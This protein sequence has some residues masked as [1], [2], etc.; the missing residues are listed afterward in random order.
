MINLD[1]TNKSIQSLL[2][3]NDVDVVVHGCNCFHIFTGTIADTLNAATNGDI[4][5]VNKKFSSYGDI[6]NLGTSSQA[7]YFIKGK[8]VTVFNFYCQ[9]TLA[10]Q[11]CEPIHWESVYN[12][13]LELLSTVES[14]HT[15]AIANFGTNTSGQSDFISIINTL[16]QRNDDELPDIDIIVVDH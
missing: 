11:D 14:D 6:N 8:E 12:G 3:N 1:I 9:Y 4:E 2:D 10:A 15:V 16:I 13:L 5:F 7:T